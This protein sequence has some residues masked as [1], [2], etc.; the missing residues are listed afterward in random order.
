VLVGGIVGAAIAAS[1]LLST[2][3]SVPAPVVTRFSIPLGKDEIVAPLGGSVR[4]SDDGTHLAWVASDAEGRTQIYHRLLG[5]MQATVLAG[6]ASGYS[7]FFSADRGSLAFVHAGSRTIK[8]LSLSGGAPSLL[9][10]YEASAAPGVWA[11][12][13]N[14]Y[15]TIQYPGVVVKV[16]STGG[17]PQPV[18]KLDSKKEEVVHNR[19][20]LL[21]GGKAI[22]FTVGGGG[23]DSYDDARIAV[24]SLDTGARKILIEGGWR[25]R[26]L[27]QGISFMH[28]TANCWPY[29]SM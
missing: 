13:D 27:R 22:L 23:M 14:I 15:T 16:A 10:P 29:R 5:D 6:T 18:T 24:Q 28:M 26:I 4:L 7:P 9:C 17:T 20:V 2:R 11:P 12:G 25:L 8:K 1:V 3:P 21:P 19:P